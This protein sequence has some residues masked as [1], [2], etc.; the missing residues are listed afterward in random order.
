MLSEHVK[1]LP[2]FMGHGTA[3]P[4]VAFKFGEGSAAYLK[5]EYGLSTVESSQVRIE[6]R[7]S[8]RVINNFVPIDCSAWG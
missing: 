2:I 1:G 8:S 4:V 7:R 6:P 5:K 3:D